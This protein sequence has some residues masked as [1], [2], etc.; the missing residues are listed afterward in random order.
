M[1]EKLIFFINF[2]LQKVQRK[3]HIA[4][5]AVSPQSIVGHHIVV[6]RSTQIDGMSSIESYTYI[7]NRCSVTRACIGRYVSIGNNVSIGPGEHGLE[8]VST[9]SHFYENIYDELTKDD[10]IIESDVW[11]GV[12]AIVLR[13]VRVGVGA[14]IAANAVVTKDV[15][16]YAV[17]AG[18]PARVV[19]YRFDEDR[20]NMLLSSHWWMEDKQE[21]KLIF[22]KLSVLPK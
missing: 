2:C 6:G 20:R 12:D 11:I 22:T 21:A 16:D 17:V 8:N 5:L 14:V 19:K 13:G 4:S 7:G 18:V 9:S 3:N 1:L 15:P 10:C